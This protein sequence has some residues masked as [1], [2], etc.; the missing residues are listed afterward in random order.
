[1]IIHRL[2]RRMIDSQLLQTQIVSLQSP[3]PTTPLPDPCVP[4]R[5]T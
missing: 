2:C 1:M 3:D 5:L 4:V